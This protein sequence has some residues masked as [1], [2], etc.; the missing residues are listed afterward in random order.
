MNKID[1]KKLVISGLVLTGIVFSVL[2]FTTGIPEGGADNYAH[3]NIA[4][5]AFRY[6]HLF[7][8]HWGKPVFT[9]LSAP[10]A[11]FGFAA[12]R[13]FNTVCGLLAAWYMWKLSVL[14]KF[15]YSWFAAVVVIFTP[16]Y[17]IMMS[18][19]MTEI[20][21]SLFLVLSV[22]LFFSE[23][24][25]ASA[26]LISFLFLART[27]GLAFELLFLIALI[28]KKQYKAIPFLTTGF[29]VF[30]FIGLVY[31]YHDFWWLYNQRPYAKGGPS[32]Y[33]RGSWYHFFTVMPNYFGNTLRILLFAG[34]ITLVVKWIQDKAKLTGDSFLLILL[35]A[36]TFWGYFFIHS[37]LWWKGETSAGLQ[38]VMAGVSPVIAI[39]TM[40]AVDFAAK[41]IRQGYIKIAALTL[42]SAFLVY[43][44][45][46]FYKR[47][48][49]YD[50]TAEVLERT[51]NWLKE[52][53]NLNH[54]LVMHNPY[55]SFATEIDAWD[56]NVVQYGFSNND[57]PETGL[58]DSTV[59]IW[60]AHFS[61]NEGKLPLE[62]IM[63]NPNF[64]VIQLFEPVVP[65]K[66]FGDNDY[67]IIVFRKIT[68]S[69][70]NNSLILEK[71]KNDQLDKTVYYREEKYFDAPFQD[72]NLE[73]RRLQSET[74]SLNY[75][76][77]LNEI[78][79][80]PAFEIPERKIDRKNGN[81]FRVKADFCR[82]DSI[83]QNRLI[84]VFSA[85]TENKSYHYVTSGIGEQTPEKNVW[86]KTDFVF[87]LPEE[88]KK[89]SIIKIYVWNM[90]KRNVLMDNFK[91]EI[92]K[93]AKD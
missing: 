79:F 4:R 40:V 86:Y 73:I 41:Y 89:G 49:G 51:T 25:Y 24:Y 20:I 68:N 85:E 50:L 13:V 66:V 54:K 35:I 7:L 12:V 77:N 65:F 71:L 60:D 38:R 22:Y 31:Y 92:S 64:E 84:M 1:E 93:Q 47:S 59:F 18:T 23:K 45:V 91:V 43:D 56:N 27:E 88:L 30:S 74:D 14:L 39:M 5:W 80:S 72:Q 81:K 63:S 82:F 70:T 26:I 6:P 10:F 36:G 21:F 19:G 57:A 61:P 69:H 17:F 16:I 2:A 90:D 87:S 15:K 52:S 55:F 67:R 11:Q 9:I 3:F 33:G 58:S 34:S 29:L 32:V 37:Y 42:I 48:I 78:E 46:Y 8:D 76:F 62:K 28:I 53:G 75:V 44:S 83:G